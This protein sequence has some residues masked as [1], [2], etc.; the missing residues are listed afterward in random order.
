[1]RATESNISKSKEKKDILSF[2][3]YDQNI[4]SAYQEIEI[5]K[6]SEKERRKINHL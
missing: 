4:F 5:K 3:K 1:M 6:N 2:P